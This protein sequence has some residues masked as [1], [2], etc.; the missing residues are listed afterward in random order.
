MGGEYRGGWA[1][2]VRMSQLRA[3]FGVTTKPEF[4]SSRSFVA[5]RARGGHLQEDFEAHRRLL[6]GAVGQSY[7]VLASPLNDLDDLAFWHFSHMHSLPVS[8]SK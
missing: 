3:R 4:Y 2:D 1:I 6:P 7:S 8:N 5:R